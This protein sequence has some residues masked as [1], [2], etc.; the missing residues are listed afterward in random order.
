MIT[1]KKFISLLILFVLAGCAGKSG[2]LMYSPGGFNAGGF[3]IEN[4][5]IAIDNIVS[6][7]ETKLP[8]KPI[9]FIL[10]DNEPTLS[11][12]I[13]MIYDKLISHGV[14]VTLI[15][16]K[17]V[18]TRKKEVDFLMYV[19]PVLMGERHIFSFVIPPPQPQNDQSGFAT[20]IW[21]IQMQG[22]ALRT[23][24]GASA[25]GRGSTVQLYIRLENVKK[26]SI[27]LLDDGQNLKAISGKEIIL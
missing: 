12:F 18:E 23:M 11:I 16:E 8:P 3:D 2:Y 24:L 5:N 17:D 4:R 21:Q 6:K 10:P 15:H 27:E 7:F 26:D 13:N 14:R 22:W 20:M 9:G 1:F 25:E 19:Y